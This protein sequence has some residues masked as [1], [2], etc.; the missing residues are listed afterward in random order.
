MPKYYVQSGSLRFVGAATCEKAAAQRAISS[1]ESM[2]ELGRTIRVNE[3][4]FD[5][6]DHETDVYL[7]TMMVLQ[8][9]GIVS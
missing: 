7:D 3:Q 4:G 5:E 1:S 2:L 8:E 6:V 9:L